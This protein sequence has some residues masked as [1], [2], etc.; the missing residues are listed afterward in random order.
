MSTIYVYIWV[1]CLHVCLFTVWVMCPW[2]SE[3][4]LPRTRV[5]DYCKPLCRCWKWN[6]GWVRCKRTQCSQPSRSPNSAFR[7][8]QKNPE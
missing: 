6:L 7:T 1:F 2:R 4:G 3:E 5:T 8:Y